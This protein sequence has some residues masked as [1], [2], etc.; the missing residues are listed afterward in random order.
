MGC[1]MQ[2]RSQPPAVGALYAAPVASQRF[3]VAGTTDF[4]LLPNSED[5]AVTELALEQRG[6][7]IARLARQIEQPR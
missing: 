1:W 3:R 5:K 7:V 4:Y 6:N 2:A